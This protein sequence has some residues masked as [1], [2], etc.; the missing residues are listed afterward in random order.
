MV[1]FLPFKGCRPA[2]RGGESIEERISPPYDVVGAE[3]LAE[4]QAMPRNIA[5]LTL[6]PVGGRYAESRRE[7]DAWLSDGSLAEDPESFYVYRQAFGGRVRT[8]FVGRLRAEGYEEGH[9]VPHEETFSKVK[10]DRLNLL[11]DME[12]HLESIFCIFDGFSPE[13][14]RDVEACETPLYDAVDGDGVLHRVSRVSDP[15]VTGRMSSELEAQRVLIADGHHRYETALAYAREN[16]GD[17]LK[18]HVLATL[19]AADDPGLE[20]LPTHRLVDAS[21][22][23]ERNA[24]AKI[25]AAME[26]E[27]ADGFDDMMSKLEKWE[28]GFAFRSGRCMLA[29]CDDGGDPMRGL[30]TYALQEA[31]LNGIYKADEGKAQVSYDADARSVKASMEAGRHDLAVLLNSPR[32]GTIREL[33]AMGRR[34]PK[35]TTYFYPKIWSGFVIYRM[36]RAARRAPLALRRRGRRRTESMITAGRSAPCTREGDGAAGGN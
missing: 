31:V 30:D 25:E 26:T 36:V 34:M 17:E 11:R 16:P 29:R 9:V 7:L 15:G 12:A 32:I 3:R 23:S 1:T 19:V 35:K 33:A 14:M 10:A 27:D 5:R 8:G 6:M 28:F 18:A 22:I 20:I 2:L 24:A 21:D 4:L 13:L